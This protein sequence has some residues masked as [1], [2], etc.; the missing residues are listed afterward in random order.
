[1]KKDFLWETGNAFSEM[2]LLVE[3]AIVLYENDAQTL[4]KLARDTRQQQAFIALDA[5]GK[6]LYN[7]RQH[8]QEVQKASHQTEED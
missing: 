3:G 8:I 6:A 7:M 5:I 1:M 4:A 2:R